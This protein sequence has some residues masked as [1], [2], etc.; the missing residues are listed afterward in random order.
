MLLAAGPEGRAA[1]AVDD[2]SGHVHVQVCADETELFGCKP[3]MMQ[4]IEEGD[5]ARVRELIETK[6]LDPNIKYP[7]YYGTTALMQA[8]N[9][10]QEAIALYLLEKG[11]DPAE[12]LPLDP[13]KLARE[14]H[15]DAV[16]RVLEQRGAGESEV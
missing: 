10:G 5:L 4:A 2:V 9:R 6:G 11:A 16:V 13:L 14:H 1:E 3:V 12:T 15:Y 8:L 7:F